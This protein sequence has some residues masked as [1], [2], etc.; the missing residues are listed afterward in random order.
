[1]ANLSVRLPDEIDR[2]LDREAE[3][4]GKSRSDLV[5]EAVGEYL[6]RKDRDRFMDDMVRAVKALNSAPDAL[7]DARV[8]PADFDAIDNT[9]NLIE[10]QER[11]AGIDPSEKWWD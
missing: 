11:A 9:I 8:I 3:I 1:M 6:T 5:R 10:A 2:D 4:S 7:K